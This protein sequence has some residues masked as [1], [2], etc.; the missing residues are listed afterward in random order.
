MEGV[1]HLHRRVWSVVQSLKHEDKLQ[2][3]GAENITLK[4]QNQ[5]ANR[6]SPHFSPFNTLM[7]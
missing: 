4:H 3:R 7:L 1:T 5:A 2:P 6:I